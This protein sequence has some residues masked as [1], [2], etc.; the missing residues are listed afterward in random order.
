M[1]VLA[2]PISGPALLSGLPRREAFPPHTPTSVDTT[3]LV[4]MPSLPYTLE[5][6][7]DI[8]TIY[9]RSQEHCLPLASEIIPESDP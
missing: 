8:Y 6:L 9:T 4:T 3:T 5:L 1:R 2:R 7:V